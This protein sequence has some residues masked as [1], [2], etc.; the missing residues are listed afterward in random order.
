MRLFAVIAVCAAF[1]APALAE[2]P[3]A[4]AIVTI[5][6]A[7][8]AVLDAGDATLDIVLA[9]EGKIT[10]LTVSKPDGERIVLVD[11]GGD[12]VTGVTFSFP[13][14]GLS[15]GDYGVNWTVGHLTAPASKSGAYMFSVK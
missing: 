4:P 15:A 8:G 12:A 7:E 10:D 1:V 2:T 14:P 11:W 6:P 9:E 5:T 3:S 13:L